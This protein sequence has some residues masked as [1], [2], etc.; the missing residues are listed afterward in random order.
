MSSTWTS[1]RPLIQSP[2]AFPRYQYRLRDEGIESSSVE[3]DLRV[4]V[5]ENQI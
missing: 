3:K 4:M 1:V 2:T 5:D